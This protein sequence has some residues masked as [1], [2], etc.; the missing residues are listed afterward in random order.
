MLS[1][2]GRHM[3]SDPDG[4]WSA[5]EA[6]RYDDFATRSFSW[7]Y[8]EKPALRELIEPLVDHRTK[9]LDLGCGGGRIITL[10]RQLGLPEKSVYGLDNDPTLAQLARQRFLGATIINADITAPP[11]PGVPPGLDLITAH[12]VFQYLT[13]EDLRAT[14]DEARR[15]LRPG[16]YM[17]VGLPHPM[18]VAEQAESCYFSREQQIIPAP[19]GGVTISSGLTVSDHINSAIDAGF[20]LVRLTEP[21][22]AEYA[23]GYGDAA[24]YT[25]GPTRLMMLVQTALL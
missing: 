5:E 6:I 8:I 14:L 20:N 21:E 22:I 10:L 13:V 19:W 17:A 12:L 15:L 18:R 24:S 11:Y 23:T 3:A 16:G 7:R 25:K 4:R 1:E 2:E 9:V